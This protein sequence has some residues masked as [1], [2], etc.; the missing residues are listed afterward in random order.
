MKMMVVRDLMIQMSWLKCQSE[1]EEMV[2][3]DLIDCW[4]RLRL[5]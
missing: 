2:E 1:T 4:L 5:E 3:I